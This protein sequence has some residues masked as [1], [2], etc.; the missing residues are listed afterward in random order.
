LRIA[1]ISLQAIS[2]WM[3]QPH[4][5]RNAGCGFADELDVAQNRVLNQ[6]AGGKVLAVPIGAV[7]NGSAGKLIPIPGL[8]TP[9]TS[10]GSFRR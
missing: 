3:G 5:V 10:G 7:G 4:L 6:L 1:T 2:G 9:V 8:E